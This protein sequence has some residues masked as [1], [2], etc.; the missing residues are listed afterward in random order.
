MVRRHRR[1]PFGVR[2]FATAL[3]ILTITKPPEAVSRM[4]PAGMKPAAAGCFVDTLFGAVVAW[5]LPVFYR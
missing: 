4:F 2:G 3:L 1:L 5:E